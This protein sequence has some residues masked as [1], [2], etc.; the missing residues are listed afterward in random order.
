M[1]AAWLDRLRTT[2]QRR[3]AIFR[4]IRKT[5]QVLRKFRIVPGAELVQPPLE[6]RYN[7]KLCLRDIL[8][9]VRIVGDVEELR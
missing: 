1:R 3:C 2:G 9:L 4:L 5:D 8:F 7:F 6:I